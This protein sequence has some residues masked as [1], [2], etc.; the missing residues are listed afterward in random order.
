MT[1]A[2]Y[3]PQPPEIVQALMAAGCGI[4]RRKIEDI[5]PQKPQKAAPLALPSLNMADLIASSPK[6]DDGAPSLQTLLLAT[7]IVYRIP[8]RDIK[9]ERRHVNVVRARQAYFWLARTLT[10]QSLPTIGRLV[11]GKDH[12]TVLH[13]VRKVDAKR[14][15]FEPQLSKILEQFQKDQGQ[16][17]T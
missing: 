9:S 8:V 14:H 4:R 2:S 15:L 16:G 17:P 5:A 1:K 6:T 7:S 10:K 11:A 3:N 13:A 12:S